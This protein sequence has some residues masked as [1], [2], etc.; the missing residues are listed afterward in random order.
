MKMNATVISIVFAGILI[1]GAV[2]LS[3]SPASNQPLSNNNVT[4]ENGKQVIEIDAKGG[5]APQQTQAKA[6]I[7]TILRVATN[8]TFDCSSALT[9]PAVGYRENLPPSGTTDI[10]IPPQKVGATVQGLCAM[11]MYNFSLKFN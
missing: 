6:G 9:I 4:M 11:G 1:A 3:N 10:E 5:Y 8:G 7:P 2:F